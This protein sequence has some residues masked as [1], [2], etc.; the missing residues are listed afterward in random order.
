VTSLAN[1]RDTVSNSCNST[2]N[3][4]ELLLKLLI[5]ILTVAGV[6]TVTFIEVGVVAMGEVVA[7]DV[8]KEI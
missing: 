7:S 3:V 2:N 1:I 5:F 8:D 6:L 4:Q